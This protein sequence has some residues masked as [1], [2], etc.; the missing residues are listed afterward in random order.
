MGLLFIP[1]TIQAGR[2][3]SPSV[4]RMIPFNIAHLRIP[5]PNIDRTENAALWNLPRTSLAP[6]L[7]LI[8]DHLS[9]LT[10][11][12]FDA[13]RIPAN[14]WR[15]IIVG[16]E[17][18]TSVALIDQHIQAP[19]AHNPSENNQVFHPVPSIN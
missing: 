19:A 18:I 10:Q 8:P 14:L 1:A 12:A 16:I 9:P 13:L 2:F 5:P 15:S 7:I 3:V 4:L 11:T 6:L 17:F